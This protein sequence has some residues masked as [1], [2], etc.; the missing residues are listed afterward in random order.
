MNIFLTLD[1]N[2]VYPLLAMLNSLVINNPDDRFDFYIGYSS[3]TDEDFDKMEKV[4]EGHDSEIHRIYI[5]SD[6][7]EGFP[8]LKRTSIETY[9][10]LLVGDLLPGDVDR[11]LYLD[12]DIV[13]NK[14]ISDFY[15]TDL[16]GNVIGAAGHLYKFNEFINEIRLG[17]LK[18]RY[19][20]AGVLL[21]D[22]K[23]WRASIT[24]ERIFKFI[25]KHAIN[26]FLADQDVVNCLFT[27]KILQLDERYMNLDEKT[28]T[29]FDKKHPITK[30]WIENNTVIIHFNGKKKP[31]KDEPYEGVLG[32]Y[33]ERYKVDG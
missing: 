4:L 9:Y 19:I 20:N 1:S 24:T 6:R 3:L 13:I 26:L 30:E 10:R 2:Y 15:N 5:S 12:P 25:E 23:K 32:E 18:G 16:K 17:G 33:F 21:I 27:G 29:D 28:V 22:L 14:S 7:F 31:W 8:K 11:V